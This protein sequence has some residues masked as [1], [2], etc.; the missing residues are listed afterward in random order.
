MSLLYLGFLL[1]SLLCMGTVDLR[2]RLFLFRRPRVA[3][4]VVAVG[5]VLFVVWDLVAIATDMYSKGDSPAMTGI[6][7]A[8][9][10]PIEELVFITFLTYITGVLHGG[11]QR[12]LAL[13]DERR[14]RGLR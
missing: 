14:E 3:L 4:G 9:H 6:D 1:V 12:L 11:S 2:F 8:P 13:A 5:F 7:V 10:L